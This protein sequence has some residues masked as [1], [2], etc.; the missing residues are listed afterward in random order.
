MVDASRFRADGDFVFG[1]PAGDHFLNEL[2]DARD[3]VLEDNHFGLV[4]SRM[5]SVLGHVNANDFHNQVGIMMAKRE[6]KRESVSS[7]HLST[8]DILNAGSS[9]IGGHEPQLSYRHPRESL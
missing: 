5:K 4:E 3:S 8:F 6:K 7:H 1:A 2:I 9:M